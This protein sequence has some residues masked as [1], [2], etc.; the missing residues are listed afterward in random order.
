L[1]ESDKAYLATLK[2]GV[3]TASGDTEGEVIASAAVAVSRAQIEATLPHFI[4]DILQIPPMYSA[5]KQNGR[6]LYELARRGETVERAARPVTVH[7]IDL[8]SFS[9][10]VL[11]LRVHC[12]KGFYVRTL[13]D[14]LGL[15]LG[16][17]AHLT[18]LRRERVG[19]FGLEGSVSVARLE[20]E[21]MAQRESHLLPV[22]SLLAGMARM[23]LDAESAWQMRHGQPVWRSRLTVGESFC[24]YDDKGGLLGLAEVNREGLLGPKRLLQTT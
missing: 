22:D 16:C 17:G 23:D 6:P 20:T 15:M 7:S 9:S 5:L 8:V 13:A 12:G 18:A 14:D 11:V 10:D 1:L 21:D 2:L 3:R 19:P 24:V 4:G